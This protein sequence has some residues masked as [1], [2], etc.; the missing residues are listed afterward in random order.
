VWMRN[1]GIAGGFGAREDGSGLARTLWL[2][3]GL[4]L[5]MKT[6]AVNGVIEIYADHVNHAFRITGY[7]Y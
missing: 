3:P 2:D 6:R 1:A 5:I 7:E 4:S